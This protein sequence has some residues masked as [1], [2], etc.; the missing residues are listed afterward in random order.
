MK[1]KNLAVATAAA[2]LLATGASAAS[3]S[4]IGSGYAS[5]TI[6]NYDLA[7]DLDG[8]TVTYLTGAAKNTTNGLYL[9][10]AA[11]ITYT[12]I[13]SEAGNLNYSASAANSWSIFETDAIGT[14]RMSTQLTAGLLNFSFETDQPVVNQGEIRNHGDAEPNSPDFAIGYYTDGTSWYAMFDDLAKID[15]DFDDFVLRIDIAPVPIP[16]AGFL[17]LG[18]LGAMGAVAR[19]RKKS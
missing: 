8:K 19:R 14:T 16:A 11:K 17:L 2:A 1:L 4:L 7:P 18:G 6:S 9:D 3:L 15:R 5:Q 10:G 12:F 13:G